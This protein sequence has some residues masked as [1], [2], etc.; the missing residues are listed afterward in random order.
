MVAH[1][2]SRLE[3][4]AVI[5]FTDMHHCSAARLITS[6]T[7]RIHSYCPDLFNKNSSVGKA[8][9]RDTLIDILI[10]RIISIMAGPYILRYET[11]PLR[12]Q[13]AFI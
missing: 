4:Q 11:Y 7:P 9:T 5:R 3:V 6:I 8:N 1:V 10:G 13:K 12:I 2:V